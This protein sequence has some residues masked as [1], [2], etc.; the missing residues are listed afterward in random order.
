M[1][2]V[3]DADGYTA[4]GETVKPTKLDI[5]QVFARKANRQNPFSPQYVPLAR[6]QN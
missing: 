5:P 2:I 1:F 6:D 3:G 4:T